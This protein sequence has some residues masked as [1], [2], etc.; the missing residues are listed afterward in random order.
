MDYFRIYVYDKTKQLLRTTDSGRTW[1]SLTLPITPA[2]N[3]HKIDSAINSVCTLDSS[4]AIIVGWNGIIYYVAPTGGGFRGVGLSQ[5]ERLEGIA[6]PSKDTGI[7]VGD[8]GTIL[9]ST[10][11]G[12]TWQSIPTNTFQLLYSVAFAN[13]TTGVAVGTS[14]EIERTTD[15]GSSWNEINN[16]LTQ[17]SV[18]FR[19]VQG[20]PD[21]T[22]LARAGAN[23]LRSTD[24]GQNWNFV[25]F[26]LDVGD[27]AGMSFYSPQIGIV[28]SRLTTSAIIPDTSYFAY[29]TDGCLTWKQ[30][31]VPMW[32]YNQILF[33]WLSDHEVLLFG[34]YGFIEDVDLS[35]PSGVTVTRVDNAPQIQV[36]PNPSNGEVRVDYTTK[37]SGPVTIE[38]WD[39]TGKK[40]GTLF[41]GEE[42]GGSH[43]QTLTLPTE[44]HGTF[45]VRLSSDGSASTTK[46][47]IH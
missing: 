21:G 36:Y 11:R 46:L 5:K 12:Q 47:N 38:L 9:Q 15:E 13:P 8:F 37:A 17:S 23:L 28:A 27:T 33:H 29:T 7:I 14:G 3:I 19:Q 22:F 45:F 35:A 20:F 2:S 40:V 31:S 41:S 6:F 30:F 43:E 10:D 18:A 44:L 1:A 32:A 42:A 16:V 34:I 25:A 4:S 39:E 26:P 24:F